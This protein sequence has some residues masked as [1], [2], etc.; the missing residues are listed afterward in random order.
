M[1]DSVLVQVVAARGD[2]AG[3]PLPPA[4]ERRGTL[5][6]CLL[7]ELCEAA[8]RDD[9]PRRRLRLQLCTQTSLGT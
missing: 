1:D 6:G 3:Y 2:V 5:H 8:A 9:D 4:V 7:A